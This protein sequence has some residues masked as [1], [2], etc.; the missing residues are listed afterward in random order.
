MAEAE[1]NEMS[2][3]IAHNVHLH[4]IDCGIFMPP[5]CFGCFEA[6]FDLK[7]NFVIMSNVNV[8]SHWNG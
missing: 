2:S 8:L 4:I 3:N 6:V 1:Q 7:S 5:L